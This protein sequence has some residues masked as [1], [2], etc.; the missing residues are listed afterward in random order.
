MPKPVRHTLRIPGHVAHLIR[1]MHPELKRKV[2]GALEI[3][4]ATPDSGKVLKDELTGLRSFRVGKFRVVY[5]V[6]RRTIEIVA[7]GPRSQI[8]KETLRRIRTESD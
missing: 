1:G 2:R 5:K 8:Y 4:S 3:I 6:S 7:I